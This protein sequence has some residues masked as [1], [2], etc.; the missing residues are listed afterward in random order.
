MKTE[1]LRGFRLS[2]VDPS[3][4]ACS[5]DLIFI[6]AEFKI[7]VWVVVRRMTAFVRGRLK[8]S[9]FESEVLN[10]CRF[11]VNRGCDGSH[12]SGGVNPPFVPN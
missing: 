8:K 1:R 3:N 2:A 5:H 12:G 10:V 4:L 6:L 7:F 11:V 9:W